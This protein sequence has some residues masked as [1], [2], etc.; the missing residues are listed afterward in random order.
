M[1][2][3]IIQP[4][5]HATESVTTQLE[6]ALFNTKLG[7]TTIKSFMEQLTQNMNFGKLLNR[8]MM[9]RIYTETFWLKLDLVIFY[10]I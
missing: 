1:I 7:I 3:K 10:K 6:M 4:L 5:N 9:V 8:N 2:A